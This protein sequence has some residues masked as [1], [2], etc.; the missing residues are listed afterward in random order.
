MT[1]A[2]LMTK[3]AE[4]RNKLETP[5]VVSYEIEFSLCGEGDLVGADA[6]AVGEVGGVEFD[7][8]GVR[9]GF[10][11]GC[12]FVEIRGWFAVDVNGHRFGVINFQHY[13]AVFGRSELGGGVGGGDGAIAGAG[14]GSLEVGF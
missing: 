6:H 1:M 7:D 3:C 4:N 10:E 2:L 11:I 14:D 12:W 9:A 13:R 8:D 5:H